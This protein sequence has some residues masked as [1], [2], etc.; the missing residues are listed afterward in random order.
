MIVLI[1]RNFRAELFAF[2]HRLNEKFSED[3]LKIA[4]THKSFIDKEVKQR[5]ELGL[6]DVSVNIKDNNELAE[7]GQNICFNYIKPYLRH[8]LPRLPEDGVR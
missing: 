7:I 5:Q 6:S 1:D 8:F 2:N 3:S 4:F